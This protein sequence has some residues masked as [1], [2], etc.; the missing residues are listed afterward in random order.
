MSSIAV[1]V[2]MSLYSFHGVN[3]SHPRVWRQC[4]VGRQFPN[5]PVHEAGEL[6]RDMFKTAE[7]LVESITVLHSFSVQEDIHCHT[8]W[9][10]VSGF[11]ESQI[12]DSYPNVQNGS[13]ELVSSEYLGRPQQAMLFEAFSEF[14]TLFEEDMFAVYLKQF[15]RSL[16]NGDVGSRDIIYRKPRFEG[17]VWS[18]PEEK[19]ITDSRVH[20]KRR[21]TDLSGN[22][23]KRNK[24]C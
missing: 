12:D 6:Y 7:P 8:I 15:S 9:F 20:R 22:S 4:Y 10:L 23:S 14:L 13:Y 3:P 24:V 18:G 11:L 19:C 5:E 16:F 21:S 2:N 17:F 1:G